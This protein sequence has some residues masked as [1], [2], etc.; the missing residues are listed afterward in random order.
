MHD[1]LLCVPT[2]RREL[3][4]LL[5]LGCGAITTKNQRRKCVLLRYI[6]LDSERTERL[7]DL[8]HVL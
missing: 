5:L 8:P 2:P 7:H 4:K 3:L 6:H 1:E